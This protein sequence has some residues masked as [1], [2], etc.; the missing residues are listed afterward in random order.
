LSLKTTMM[1][2]MALPVM[3]QKI[4]KPSGDLRRGKCSNCSW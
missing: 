2:T 3:S 4:R 1:M